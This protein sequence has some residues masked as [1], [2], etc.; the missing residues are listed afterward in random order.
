M[1]KTILFVL[2]AIMVLFVSCGTNETSTD[3]SDQ[4][5][6]LT[7]SSIVSED[8]ATTSQDESSEPS[9]EESS[10]PSKEESTKP[11]KE[12]SSEPSKEEST[13]PPKE[14]STEPSKEESTE[15]PK[16]ESTEPSK[17]ESSKPS[18]EESKVEPPKT[19]GT[20]DSKKKFVILSSYVSTFMSN[21]LKYFGGAS[22]GELKSNI[23]NDEA[24]RRNELLEQKY[25]IEIFE[26][27]LYDT[28]PGGKGSLQELV[29]NSVK[30][31]TVDFNMLS[32]SLYNMGALSLSDSIVD[33]NAISVFDNFENEWWN[34]GFI[35]DVKVNNV[36]QYALG[37]ITFAALD[38]V[39]CVYYNDSLQKELDLPDYYQYVYDGSWTYDKLFEA[40]KYINKD[41]NESKRYS[42]A[43]LNGTH[44][45]QLYFSSGQRIVERD[46]NGLLVLSLN[47]NI[48]N[49]IFRMFLDDYNDIRDVYSVDGYNNTVSSA[50]EKFANKEMVFFIYTMDMIDAIGN[51]YNNS[52]S[53]L[54]LPKYDEEQEDY[55]SLI[56]PYGACAIAIPESLSANDLEFSANVVEDMAKNSSDYINAFKSYLLE[57][58]K[59]KDDNNTKNMLDIIYDTSRCDLGIINNIG[60]IAGQ[61]KNSNSPF[62][63][64]NKNLT[65]IIAEIN[66]INSKIT[67]K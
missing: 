28:N 11:S 2:V 37:D 48:V 32:A 10:E 21:P 60:N 45:W 33:M 40:G 53:L 20:T 61:I 54:P 16:E 5:F 44:R 14:E 27:I 58:T 65:S 59:Q 55:H 66:L 35:D 36:V 3:P 7:N 63:Y 47:E 64:I 9:N 24:L 25:D 38:T 23:V 52:F 43:F 13:E 1:K 26:K 29:E 19:S 34:Q 15:P 22:E 49:S 67:S 4:S 62:D 51:T 30:S 50:I 6:E 42:Y 31:E 56:S 18:K 39:H 8:N 12:E 41:P 17:E 46:S 57:Y